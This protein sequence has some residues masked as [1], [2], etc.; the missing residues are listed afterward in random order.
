M[1]DFSLRSACTETDLLVVLIPQ[2]LSPSSSLPVI[3]LLP[4]LHLIRRVVKSEDLVGDEEVLC[5]FTAGEVGVV[6]EIAASLIILSSLRR[7]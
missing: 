1:Q 5:Y 3:P 2:L 7:Q 6:P 4:S